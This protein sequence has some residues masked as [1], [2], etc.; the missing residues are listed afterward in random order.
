MMCIG[1]LECQAPIA[2]RTAQFSTAILQTAP[3]L[4]SRIDPPNKGVQ[5]KWIN[6]IPVSDWRVRGEHAVSSCGTVNV[7]NRTWGAQRAPAPSTRVPMSRWT[8]LFGQRNE[9]ATSS[10]V[11]EGRNYQQMAPEADMVHR[12]WSCLAI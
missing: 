12:N 7:G 5:W 2:L 10:E 1:R 11:A 9:A 8:E 4:C 6:A 3:S